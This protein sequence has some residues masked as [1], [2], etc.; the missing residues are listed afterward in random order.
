[1]RGFEGGGHGKGVRAYA[2]RG[3]HRDECSEREWDGGELF[4]EIQD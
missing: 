1:M 2:Q 3:K 4:E